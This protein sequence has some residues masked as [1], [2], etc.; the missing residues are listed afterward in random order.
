MGVRLREDA[1]RAAAG[2]KGEGCRGAAHN[3]GATGPSACHSGVRVVTTV[4]IG[5]GGSER[6]RNRSQ[7]PQLVGG[8]T[9]GSALR[10]S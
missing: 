3:D 8:H 10:P 7:A 4:E 2:A 1:P 9:V 5:E 6:S